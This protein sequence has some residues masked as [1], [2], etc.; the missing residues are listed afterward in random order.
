[1]AAWVARAVVPLREPP[2]AL[3]VALAAALAAAWAA[4][5]VAAVGVTS[6]AGAVALAALAALHAPQSEVSIP[7][8][9]GCTSPMCSP[10]ELI[11]IWILKFRI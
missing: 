10:P 1:M 4:A 9:L 11:K 5:W 6:A 2:V 3:A 8:L 7:K